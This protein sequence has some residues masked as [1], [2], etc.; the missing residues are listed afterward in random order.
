MEV[1]YNTIHRNNI[2]HYYCL[3]W[4]TG[5][6]IVSGILFSD[7]QTNQINQDSINIITWIKFILYVLIK[8]YYLQ[9]KNQNTI[10]DSL[11]ERKRSEKNR[12][13]NWSK[14]DG[15]VLFIPNV[16]L[17]FFGGDFFA[18]SFLLIADFAQLL[19]LVVEILLWF[20][21]FLKAT[22]KSG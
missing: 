6:G 8:K 10:F 3:G 5:L 4:I 20:L 7:D 13:K 17:S 19:A 11:K 21:H 14:S 9:W 2:I 1:H 18:H 22:D 16:S 15:W 12:W